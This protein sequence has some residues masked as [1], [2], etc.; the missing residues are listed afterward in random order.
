MPLM[1]IGLL[2]T[3]QCALLMNMCHQRAASPPPPHRATITLWLCDAR[4]PFPKWKHH[5]LTRNDHVWTNIR[6]I[7]IFFH[8][9]V[10]D[11]CWNSH[12]T[13]L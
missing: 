8:S 11:F 10:R 3:Y 7:F 12:L 13:P 2:L 5:A 4:L 1:K 9:P 6:I